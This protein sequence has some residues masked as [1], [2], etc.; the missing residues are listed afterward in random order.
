MSDSITKWHE[1]QEAKKDSQ[2]ATSAGTFIYE[3]PDGG[4]TVTARPF[5]GDIEDRVV[6]EHP[7]KEEYEIKQKAYR[8]LCEEDERVIRMAMKILDIG[9]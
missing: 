5:G 6:I 4:K 9:E 7:Q 8:L 1:M 2:T 3:S